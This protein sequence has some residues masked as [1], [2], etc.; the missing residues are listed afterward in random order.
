V[1]VS[2]ED[3]CAIGKLLADFCHYLDDGEVESWVNLFTDDGV[4][5]R[6]SVGHRH[7]GSAELRSFIEGEITGGVRGVH[8]CLNPAIA[9]DGNEGHATSDFLF[10]YQ[11]PARPQVVATGR[12]V[13]VLR[14]VDD[15][16]K[17]AER[18]MEVR[19]TPAMPANT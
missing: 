9:T 6:P 14:R 8:L 3:I 15:Q 1:S 10:V 13:D 2:A 17:F 19:M 18:T 5:I 7:K 4:F 12:L 16:W 11:L